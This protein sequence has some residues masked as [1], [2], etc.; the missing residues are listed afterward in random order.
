MPTSEC[1]A[2]IHCLI[3]GQ[4]NL[5]WPRVLG[6]KSVRWD[7]VFALVKQLELLWDCWKPL[8]SLDH[9][10]LEELWV[11]YSLRELVFNGDGV[12]TGIEPPFQQLVEKY[13]Q[14]K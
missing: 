13:F 7:Q 2:D 14:S 8:K 3:P 6:Q 10:N 12:Q 11:C 5:L 9:F 1:A 4:V